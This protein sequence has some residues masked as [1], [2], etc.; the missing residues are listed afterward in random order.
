MNIYLNLLWTIFMSVNF[1]WIIFLVV[2]VLN[3]IA[4]YQDPSRYTTESTCYKMSCKWFNFVAGLGTF[5]MDVLT[6]IGLW[7]TIG[8]S[9]LKWLPD[10]WY[11]PFIIFGYAIITQITIDSETVKASDDTLSPPPK[12]L[13][14]KKWRVAL[15]AAILLLDIVMFTQIYI[16]SSLNN[17]N[18]SRVRVFDVVIGNQFGG[19]KTGNK[20]QFIF[21][22]LGI[23]GVLLDFAA[24]YVTYTSDACTYKLPVSWNF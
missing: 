19:W 22:W 8:P 13:W 16:D 6:F 5:T 15:Y 14:S 18:L 17:Y 11:L 3:F 2:C 10:Y 20:F 23:V 1:R 12:N 24:L 4:F 7:Y 9:G 21:A